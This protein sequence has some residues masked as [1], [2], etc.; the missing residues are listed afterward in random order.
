MLFT[1]LD[2]R[3]F[4]SIGTLMFCL[5][6]TFDVYVSIGPLMFFQFGPLKFCYRNFEVFHLG[7]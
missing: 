3:G 1:R 4:L 7:L 2:F 6:M 5:N